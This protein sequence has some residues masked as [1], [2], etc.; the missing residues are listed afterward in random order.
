MED[1]I[2]EAVKVYNKIASIYS[3]HNFP[4]LMQFQ[5]TKFQSFLKGKRLLDAGCGVGRDVDYFVEDGYDIIGIDV[6]K[7]MIEEAKKLVPKGNFK[8]M[9]FRKMSF[10]DNS[11]DGVWCMASLYHVAPKEMPKVLKE[12]HRVLDEKGVLYLAVYEG[13]G[14]KEVDDPNYKEKRT[15]YYYNQEKMQEY[16]ED[17]GFSIIRSEVNDTEEH[18]WLEVYARKS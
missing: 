5:L 13:T 14:K 18:K 15:F 10:K 11:F 2:K 6:S 3:E 9:D 17:A 8:V 4:K 16:L 12:F 1:K 7:K